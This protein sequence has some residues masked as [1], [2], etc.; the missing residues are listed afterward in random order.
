MVLGDPPVFPLSEHHPEGRALRA[1]FLAKVWE[2]AGAM[3][4]QGKIE[5]GVG[6]FVDGVVEDGAFGRFPPEVQNLTLDN[7]CNSG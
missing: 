3:L 1:D 2:P 7:A 5:D 6:V 4:Q